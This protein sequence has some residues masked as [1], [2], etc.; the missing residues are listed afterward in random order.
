MLGKP[1]D[2][3]LNCALNQ[4]I[5]VEYNINYSEQTPSERLFVKV[6]FMIVKNLFIIR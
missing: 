1:K 2:L 5:S 4:T 6:G 3:E